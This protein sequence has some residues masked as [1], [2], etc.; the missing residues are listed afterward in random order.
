MTLKLPK[1]LLA[2]AGCVYLLGGVTPA[3]AG[4]H[5]AC[6]KVKD[7]L[8]KT[9][10]PGIT[11]NSNTGHPTQ[12]GCTIS[13]GSKLCCDAVDKVGHPPVGGPTNPGNTRKFCCYKVKCAKGPSSVLGVDDQFGNRPLSITTPKMLCAPASPSGAFLDASSVF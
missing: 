8:V 4:D 7:T 5:L 3:S 13:T 6:Y 10:F 1:L 11:L 9:K 12:T 2:A